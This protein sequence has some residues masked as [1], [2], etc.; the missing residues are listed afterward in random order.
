[1][2]FWCVGFMSFFPPCR[3]MFFVVFLGSPCR[4][5]PQHAMN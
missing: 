4:K 2:F 3:K 1:M 5:R